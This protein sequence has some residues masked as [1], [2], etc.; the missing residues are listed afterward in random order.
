MVVKKTN[1]DV[2]AKNGGSKSTR[3]KTNEATFVDKNGNMLVTESAAKQDE[4]CQVKRQ[5]IKSVSLTDGKG[6]SNTQE[7]I[8]T[9][10]A[11][12]DT[13]YELD[14]NKDF[15]YTLFCDYRIIYSSLR[16][17][18]FSTVNCLSYYCNNYL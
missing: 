10:Q 12:D 4:K 6:S 11:H 9:Y 7:T 2:K 15:M 18:W 13:T 16:A 3:A 1:G 5:G 17:F 14:G 8:T